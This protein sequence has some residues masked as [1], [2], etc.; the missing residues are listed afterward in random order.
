MPPSDYRAYDFCR[1]YTIHDM[2][3]HH[4]NQFWTRTVMSACHSEPAI[5]HAALAVAGAHKAYCDKQS[6]ESDVVGVSSLLTTSTYSHYDQALWYLKKL[7]AV[8]TPQQYEAV[9]IVCL[10]LLTFDMIAG[11]YGEAHLHLI[12]GRRIIKDINNRKSDDVQVPLILPPAPSTTMD[13]INYSFALM[14]IQSVNFGSMKSHFK[15]VADSK[16]SDGCCLEIPMSFTNLDDAWRHMLL[17]FSECYSLFDRINALGSRK[18]EL[19]TDDL[20]F[21]DQQRLHLAELAKWKEAFD[22]SSVRT[23][24][25]PRSSLADKAGI[26]ATLLKI[27]HL[28]LHVC[29]SAALNVGNEMFY[30]TLTPKFRELVELCEDL[31]PSLATI[32]VEIGIIQPL[33]LAGCICRHPVIRRRIL[34]LLSRARKEGYWDSKLIGMITRERMVFEEELAG[35]VYDAEQ[36]PLYDV[37]L[38]LLIP[39]DARWSES[40]MFFVADDYSV[41]EVTFRRR[42]LDLQLLI[43]GED[44][45]ETRTKLVKFK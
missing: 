7:M 33:F 3:S 12:H 5:L 43:E 9:L 30:D 27:Q 32:T 22:N 13:E 31:L 36:P 16:V 25:T 11:R 20:G 23:M 4:L 2:A 29:L 44:E 41:A 38:A 37:D 40:W 17:L 39:R 8:K 14:D 6:G 19:L 42:K 21:R 24:S 34:H 28:T 15:L 10:V 45:H 18:Y 35:Y 1:R 26:K